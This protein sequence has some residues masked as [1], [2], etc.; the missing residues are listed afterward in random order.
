M[1]LILRRA[2][3]KHGIYFHSGNGRGMNMQ[4]QTIDPELKVP[5]NPCL[6]L[7]VGAVTWSPVPTAVSEPGVDGSL[8]IPAQS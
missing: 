8:D 3:F 6:P 4:Q 7:A 5:T 1:T 2:V